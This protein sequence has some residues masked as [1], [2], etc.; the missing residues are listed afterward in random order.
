MVDAVVNSFT[1]TESNS[2]WALVLGGAT[3]NATPSALTVNGSNFDLALSLDD[4]ASAFYDRLQYLDFGS[5]LVRISNVTAGSSRQTVDLGV[6]SPDFTFNAAGTVVPLPA[7]AL[8]LLTGLAGLG[9]AAR[10]RRKA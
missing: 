1:L 4:D 9:V 3:L 6:Q 7:P 5:S 8:L 2:T 10:R